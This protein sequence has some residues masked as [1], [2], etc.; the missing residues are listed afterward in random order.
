MPNMSNLKE[1]LRRFGL[2]AD[3][4][5]KK[6][7]AHRIPEASRLPAGATAGAAGGAP[8]G[9]GGE[10]QAEVC[11]AH[12]PGKAR[13]CRR[14][15]IAGSAYCGQHQTLDPTCARRKVRGCALDK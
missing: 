1:S 8:G 12:L 15:P 6:E 5:T 10:G 4:D 7:L 11:A 9:E 13:G 2:A 3:G 14:L